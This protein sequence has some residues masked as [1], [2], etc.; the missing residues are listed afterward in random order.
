MLINN[1][2]RMRIKKE[3]ISRVKAV[4]IAKA[5]IYSKN[6][7]LKKLKAKIL[8]IGLSTMII[9]KISDKHYSFICNNQTQSEHKSGMLIPS[10]LFN[11]I[12]IQLGSFGQIINMKLL[13]PKS[14]RDA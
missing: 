2:E 10:N 6:Y 13:Y 5:G 1:F 12:Q 9:K 14:K 7:E 4:D 3:L 11:G 8:R